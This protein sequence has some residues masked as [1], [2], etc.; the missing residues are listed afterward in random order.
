MIN[1][2]QSGIAS[3]ERVFELLDAEEEIPDDRRRAARRRGPGP[4]RVRGRLVL[5]QPRP[6]AHRRPR[7]WWPSR[8]RPS[9]SSGPTGAGKT[10]LVNLLMRF[11]E[12]DGGAHHRS[13]AATSR[14]MRRARPALAASA[15]CCR[16]PGCSAAPSARTSPTATRRPPRSRSSRRPRPPT[17]TASCTRCPTATTRSS[18]TRAAPSAP[19]RSSCSPSPG[20]SSPTRRSS[21]STRPPARSTPA[22]RCSSRRRW[23]RCAQNRTSFVIAHRLSTIRDADIIL[24]MEDGRIV[25]QGDHDELLEPRRR[26][27]PPLQRPV[28]GP[29]RRG[30]LTRSSVRRLSR[31]GLRLAPPGVQNAGRKRGRAGLR[32]RRR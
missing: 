11:Y 28:R 16:T 31:P 24:V 1:V 29:G 7:R 3:A 15:W 2:F 9:P 25:E 8:A 22:P 5:L 19:A 18:T 20:R 17:S 4:G 30:R 10:T 13:T 26:L 21:S 6:P 23:P 27:R 12:L 32:R 14:D